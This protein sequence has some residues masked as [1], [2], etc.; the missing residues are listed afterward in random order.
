M[1][2]DL[3]ERYRRT[4]PT[5]AFM[6]RVVRTYRGLG[7]SGAFPPVVT[8]WSGARFGEREIRRFG[9]ATG[10]EASSILF[11]HAFAFRLVMATLTHRSFP[12]PIW[13]ALQVRNRLVAHR[14]LDLDGAYDFETRVVGHRTLD[15]G[16][17]VDLATTARRGG[18]DPEWESLVSVYYRGRFAGTK[19]VAPTSP[20]LEGAREVATFRTPQGGGW[21]FGGLTGDYNGVHLWSGYARRFGFAGAFLHPQAAV[22]RCL[23]RLPA[24]RGAAQR[25][26]L[27]IKGPVF[28][29]TEVV[30]SALERDGA[31]DFGLAIAGDPR[32]A[33]A[34]TWAAG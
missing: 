33:L 31:T 5:L 21:A 26:D 15:K 18:G 6:P 27:W 11:P 14:P 7:S 28:Y 34:G 1:H 3:V 9:A 25:L 19:T 22:G 23:A 12:L 13:N 16:V 32:F 20:A 17:E 4:P 24:P 2:P 29:R 8:S 10:L 30:L